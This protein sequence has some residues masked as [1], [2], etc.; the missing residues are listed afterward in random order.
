M[1]LGCFFC[2][3]CLFCFLKPNGEQIHSPFKGTADFLRSKCSQQDEIT[4]LPA[5]RH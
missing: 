2:C 3:C 4:N 1:F 5:N